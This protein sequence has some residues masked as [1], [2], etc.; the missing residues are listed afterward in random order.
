MDT[1]SLISVLSL[2]VALAALFI[3]PYFSHRQAVAQ[4]RQVWINDLRD[5]VAELLSLACT[6]EVALAFREID[7]E[8]PPEDYMRL[9]MLESKIELLLNPEQELHRQLIALVHALVEL[10][11]KTRRQVGEKKFI[12]RKAELELDIT[13]V[14]Q[15]I[16]RNE[17]ARTKQFIR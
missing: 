8:P 4:M 3:A 12:D 2:M 6:P 16:I 9:M 7:A 13:A 10:I 1:P 15:R 17:W 14:T 11:H 5:R